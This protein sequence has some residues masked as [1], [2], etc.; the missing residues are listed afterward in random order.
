LSRT[1]C[2]ADSRLRS[3][4]EDD[5]DSDIPSLVTDRSSSMPS[6]VFTRFSIGLG[7]AAFHFLDAA[8]F[9]RSV[10][11]VTIGKSMFGN[12]STASLRYENAP[13]LQQ[14]D[15]HG[16]EHR[17]ANTQVDDS[18][19]RVRFLQGAVSRGGSA[20]SPMRARVPAAAL[21]P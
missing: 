16:G 20:G 18:F 5:E 19:M 21:S 15:E 3:E 14:G 10:V 8:T 6:I 11:T 13:T 9:E 4:H 17:P 1:S 7:H 12:R 2:A